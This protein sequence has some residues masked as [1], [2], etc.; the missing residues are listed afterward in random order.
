MDFSDEVHTSFLIV[1]R[2]IRKPRPGALNIRR[3]IHRRVVVNLAKSLVPEFVQQKRM[4][5]EILGRP[6]AAAKYVA[7]TFRRQR[8]L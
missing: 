5:V 3:E 1:F 2:N 8:V 4:A 7:Q 6:L